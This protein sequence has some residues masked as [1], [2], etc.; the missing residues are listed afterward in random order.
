[1]TAP[2]ATLNR[3]HAREAFSERYFKSGWAFFIPYL[4]A[5]LVYAMTGWR[6]HDGRLSLE[7]VYCALHGLHV[8]LAFDF[9]WRCRAAWRREWSFFAAWIC[10]AAL[11][12]LPGLYLEFPSDAWEHYVRINDW[13]A[14][15]MIRANSGWK[16]SSY[17]L[18]YSLVGHS[19][20][21]AQVSVLAG[22]VA[23]LAWLAC[24]QSY[25]L[26][27]ALDFGRRSAFL[28]AMLQL[29][30]YGN[31]SFAF[32]R[33]YGLGSTIVAHIAA[34][35]LVRHAVDFARAIVTGERPSILKS[36]PSSLLLIALMAFNHP[37]ALLIVGCAI[38]GI[39]GW[40]MFSLRRRAAAVGLA[41][42][43]LVCATAPWWSMPP[44]FSYYTETHWLN[45]WRGFALFS[46]D[47][48]AAARA[49]AVLGTVG[50]LNLTC[51]TV[52]LWRNRL[53]AWL[54]I[55]PVAALLLPIS[56]APLAYVL[57]R[58]SPDY[59]VVASRILL[60][61]PSCFAMI[62]LHRIWREN[63][64]PGQRLQS[65]SPALVLALFAAATLPGSA[66]HFNRFWHALAR[67]PD[68]LEQRDALVVVSADAPALRRADETHFVTL[69]P[70]G[71]VV[72]ATG[73]PWVEFTDRLISYPQL[74]APAA[75]FENARERLIERRETRTRLVLPDPFALFTP[76][77]QAGQLS[78]HWL[79]REI[80]LGR[81]G[82]VEL[83]DLG[84]SLGGR[85]QPTPVGWRFAYFPRTSP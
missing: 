5:Y 40:M 23:G 85:R 32:H 62:E 25:R 60:G 21:L 74:R 14:I 51:A 8:L 67:V 24:W 54:T 73:V 76:V 55:A 68:D 80:Q 43:L 49:L 79:E 66:P 41:A 82:A 61:I 10:L 44:I 63:D 83:R 70:F 53:V 2:A 35:A 4:A 22:Y 58:T 29:F 26:A 52:L 45:F 39:I 65:G 11:I 46:P 15:D 48:P 6:I 1:V 59:I 38:L 28:A 56:A 72:T 9:L 7:S 57:S 20:P 47:S 50:L 30:C 33:Y 31:F 36:L 13:S 19:I 69:P 84:E 3:V 75:S 64:W 27:R 16:K 81:A 42:L 77:S 18:P 37:Q 34:F 12:A 71:C 17:F 78:Q